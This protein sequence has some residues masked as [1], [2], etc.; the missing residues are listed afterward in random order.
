MQHGNFN[1]EVIQYLLPH[2]FGDEE[3]GIS[4]LARPQDGPRRSA[5]ALWAAKGLMFPEKPYLP[6]SL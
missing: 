4:T 3:I 2:R 6:H 1:P 5:S